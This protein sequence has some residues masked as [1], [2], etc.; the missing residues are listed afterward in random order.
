MADLVFVSASCRASCQLADRQDAV[1]EATLPY[2][3]PDFEQVR[4]EF[5][6]T[7]MTFL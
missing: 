3:P 4:Y 1:S 7:F 5:S 2:S 6:K